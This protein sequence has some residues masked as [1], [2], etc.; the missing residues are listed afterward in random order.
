MGVRAPLSL[1]PIYAVLHFLYRV[2]DRTL[3]NIGKMHVPD[4]LQALR[5]SCRQ[6]WGRRESAF[7]GCS[8]EESASRLL[9]PSCTHLFPV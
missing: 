7:D 4:G 8:V 9:N 5:S 6:K 3:S 2:S 1:D